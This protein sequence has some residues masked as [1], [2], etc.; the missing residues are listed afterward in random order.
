M[1]FMI[2]TISSKRFIRFLLSG[3]S[4]AFV[5]YASFILLYHYLIKQLIL[6]NVISFCAGLITSF[7]LNKKWVFSSD[8]GIATQVVKYGAL[9]LFNVAMSSTVVWFAVSEIGINSW[10]AKILVMALIAAWNYVIFSKYIFVQ[11]DKV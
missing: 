6:A 8:T 4:A 2:Q 11:K 10:I 9:A 5:E 1:R 7:L 3:V